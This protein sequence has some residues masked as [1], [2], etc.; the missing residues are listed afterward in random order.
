MNWLML[1]VQTLEECVAA[2]QPAAVMGSDKCGPVAS[3]RI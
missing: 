2:I 3:D 1:L